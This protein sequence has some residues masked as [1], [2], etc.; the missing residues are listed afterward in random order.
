MIPAAGRFGHD[1]RAST[2]AGTPCLTRAPRFQRLPYEVAALLL[3]ASRAET[4]Q[5]RGV[6]RPKPL[7]PIEAVE[8]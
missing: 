4:K 5:P 1:G 2:T 6:L 3:V 7:A 8:R